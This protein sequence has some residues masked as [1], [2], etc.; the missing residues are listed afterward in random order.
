MSNTCGKLAA[1]SFPQQ[2]SNQEIMKGPAE[3]HLWDLNYHSNWKVVLSEH[4]SVARQLTMGCNHLITFIQTW[5]NISHTERLQGGLLGLNEDEAPS[6]ADEAVIQVFDIRGSALQTFRIPGR[7]SGAN[8][9]SN[10]SSFK[11]ISDELVAY[12]LDDGI[13]KAKGVKYNKFPGAFTV[14]NTEITAVNMASNGRSAIVG[15][16]NGSVHIIQIT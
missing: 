13:F 1:I 15:C 9:A 7:F 12:G 6:P 11:N 8:G 10:D 4:P 16:A 14:N 2:S 3:V 5:K